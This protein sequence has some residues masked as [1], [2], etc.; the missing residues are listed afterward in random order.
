MADFK[1]TARNKMRQHS[2]R[3]SYDEALVYSIIDAAPICHVG[4][5][6]EGR[7][8]VIPMLHA[9]RNKELLLHGSTESRLLQ[10]VRAGNELCIS[11]ALLDGIV[12]AKSATHHSLNYRSAVLFGTGR[13]LETAE[14]K[15]LAFESFT[16]RLLP[17]RWKEVRKP[18]LSDLR[19]TA[20][21]AISLTSASAKVR[22]G[23]PQDAEEDR[24]LPVWAGVLPVTQILGPAQAAEYTDPRLPPPFYPSS[25]W[26]A[27]AERRAG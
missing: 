22:S 26:A 21:V 3:V 8:V 27:P 9:R 6:E 12:L 7:P 18:S 25:P 13:P 17:G 11:L 19:G 2:E 14:E 4:F 15:L 23:P 5:V 24:L 16:E 20:V 10:Y 1:V